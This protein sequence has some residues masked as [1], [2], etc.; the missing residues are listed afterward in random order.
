M[1]SELEGVNSVLVGIFDQNVN[2]YVIKLYLMHMF[3]A[4]LN[5]IGDTVDLLFNPKKEDTSQNL[6]RS[7]NYITKDFF[8]VKIFEVG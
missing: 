4:F 3:T 8:Q 2:S 6:D 7:F 5:F 1:R